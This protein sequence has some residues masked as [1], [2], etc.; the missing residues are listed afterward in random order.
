MAKVKYK[1]SASE[2]KGGTSYQSSAM[3]DDNRCVGSGEEDCRT[4]L[5]LDSNL[6]YRRHTNLGL[7]PLIF[8]FRRRV[9]MCLRLKDHRRDT[10]AFSVSGWGQVSVR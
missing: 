4:I 6:S 9:S 2:S 5:R 10:P 3:E 7:G 8:D 1:Q